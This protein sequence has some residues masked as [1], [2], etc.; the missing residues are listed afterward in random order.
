[1]NV[2]QK[3]KMY[4]EVYSIINLMN[5]K[6]K[7]KLPLKLYELI[8]KERETAYNPVFDTRISLVEQNISREA[9][10]MLVLLQLNYWC[11]TNEEKEEINKILKDNTTKVQQ[12]MREMYSSE[13]IFKN[14]NEAREKLKEKEN[15]A[16]NNLNN[17]ENTKIDEKE[18]GLLKNVLKKIGDTLRK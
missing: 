3:K 13:N 18:K 7:K 1:M 10:A 2:N 11:D 12:K 16:N 6:Y 15:I 8:E 9:V 4:S 17:E 14:L 5:E